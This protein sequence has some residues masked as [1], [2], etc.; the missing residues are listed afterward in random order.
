MLHL[1][2]KFTTSVAKTSMA[3]SGLQVRLLPLVLL[4]DE[5]SNSV[6]DVLQNA[7]RERAQRLKAKKF[8]RQFSQRKAMILLGCSVLFINFFTLHSPHRASS[9]PRLVVCMYL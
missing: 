5:S 6:T 2:I 3:N 7:R 4:C 9:L 8:K 1:L